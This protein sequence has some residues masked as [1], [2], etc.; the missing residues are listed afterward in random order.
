MEQ[1]VEPSLTSGQCQWPKRMS[2]DKYLGLT[3]ETLLFLV[4]AFS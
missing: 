2:K 4:R 1:V 3:E